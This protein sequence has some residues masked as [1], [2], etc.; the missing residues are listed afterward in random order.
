MTNKCQLLKNNSLAKLSWVFS[1]HPWP[2]VAMAC[3]L[4]VPAGWRK[5]HAWSSCQVMGER[6]F[7]AL[8]SSVTQEPVAPTEIIFLSVGL[9]SSLE[10]IFKLV[11]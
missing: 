11:F 10:V 3:G 5:D 7:G 9:K 6:Q 8:P 4:P 2:Q 1:G